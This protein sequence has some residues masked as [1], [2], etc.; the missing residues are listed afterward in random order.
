[1]NQVEIEFSM[2]DKLNSGLDKPG[3][4]R[5][6]GRQGR[7]GCR[8]HHRAHRRPEGADRYVEK[9]SQGSL[10]N[11]M[12]GWA[13]QGPDGDAREIEACTKALAEDKA[14]PCL[15]GKR[16]IKDRP[17][18]PRRLSMELRELL[19]AMARDASRGQAEHPVSIRR[20]LPRRATFV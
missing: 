4:G 10:R 15:I 5:V 18:P 2:R 16:N 13:R 9:L 1:M 8:G 19:D 14:Y 11:S 12:T 7:K 17:P 20:W 3:I 6:L